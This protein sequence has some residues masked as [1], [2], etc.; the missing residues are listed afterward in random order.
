[1][2]NKRMDSIRLI[3]LEAFVALEK[4]RSYKLAG[5]ELQIDATLV[6]RYVDGLEGWLFKALVYRCG[7]AIKITPDGKKFLA[8]ATTI[9]DTLYGSR[10]FPSSEVV[11]KADAAALEAI[12]E[13]MNNKARAEGTPTT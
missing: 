7:K 8:K 11:R 9:I 12:A 10:R 2:S 5:D 1:M 13:Y 4:H 3:W 6:K